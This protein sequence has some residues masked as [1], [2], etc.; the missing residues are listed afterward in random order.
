MDLKEARGRL[1]KLMGEVNEALTS[2]ESPADCFCEEQRARL[3]SYQNDGKA[4]EFI[5]RVVRE[6]LA[7]RSVA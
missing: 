2:Y 5:E 7:A 1:C 6:A 4:I 3:D